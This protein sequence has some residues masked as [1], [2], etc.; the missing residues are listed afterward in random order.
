MIPSNNYISEFF[1]I[2][3]CQ[4]TIKIPIAKA[5]NITQGHRVEDNKWI[6]HF[7]LIDSTFAKYFDEFCRKLFE[8]TASISDEYKGP[9]AVLVFFN[10]WKKMLST[11]NIRKEDI[12][13]VIGE[14]LFLKRY[15]I[16]TYGEIDALSSW[17][18]ANY[19]KQDFIIKYTWYEIKTVRVGAL[20]ATISSLEQLDNPNDG[21][22]IIIKLQE[23]TT[24][25]STSVNLNMLYKMIHG[26]LIEPFARMMFENALEIYNVPNKE[27][28]GLTFEVIG[29]DNYTV[30][31]AFPKLLPGDV[32]KGIDVKQ[33]SI[34]IDTIDEFKES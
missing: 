1:L 27:Y 13:G 25:S 6:I 31:D 12:Q 11:E 16:P 3:P 15:M 7:K 34:I 23:S 30:T 26:G 4:S 17:T 32:P 28:D 19:G 21:H 22:L 20:E 18:R 9:D 24:A 14:L 33:Y 5:I 10:D 2:S 8:S 29:I